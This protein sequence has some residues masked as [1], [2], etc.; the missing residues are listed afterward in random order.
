MFDNFDDDDFNFEDY[1]NESQKEFEANLE[2]YKQ[3]MLEAAIESN[4]AA[5]VEK[6]IAD[7]HLRNMDS[8]ELNSLKITLETMIE[9]YI[10]LEEYERCA[11]LQKHLD[12]VVSLFE[13]KRTASQDI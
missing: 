7:W 9:H 5:I 8:S 2:A 10:E 3:R 11:L 4:Y 1:M 13:R 6:G 12:N